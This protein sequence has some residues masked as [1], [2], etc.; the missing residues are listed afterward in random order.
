[1]PNPNDF[2]DDK[3]W[4]N[5]CIPVMVGEGKDQDQAVAAC[6]NMWQMK[7]DAAKYVSSLIAVKAIG[8]YELDV[9]GVP[10]TGS[11][12]DGQWY[13]PF[14]DI[15]HEAFT[16]PLIAYQHGIKQGGKALDEKPLIIGKSVYGSLRKENDGWHVRVILDKAKAV[17][18]GIM[19]AAR[20]HQVAVSSGSIPHLA[21]L[22]VNGK[23]QQYE[24]NRPGRIAVWPLGEISL[25]EKGNGNVN[26][27]SRFAVAL[28]VMKAMYKDAGLLF[29]DVDTHGEAE[30]E[31]VKRR[32][33]VKSQAIKTL[34]QIK[35]LGE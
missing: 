5:A 29:P 6:Q 13:D 21:R 9:T 25:W 34:E 28:P 27:A 4:M 32:A 3:E 12:S 15:M 26:P 33:L 16:T 23:L 8:D 14:T 1:M 22:E 30:A 2:T 20:N 24:K 11:D 18:D 7:N 10:F 17:T 19:Q 31:Q 35:K